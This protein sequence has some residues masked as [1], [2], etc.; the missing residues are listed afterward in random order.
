M[1]YPAKYRVAF[2]RKRF[3]ASRRVLLRIMGRMAMNWLVVHPGICR[4]WCG[5]FALLFC[6]TVAAAPTEYEVKAAFIHNV[7]K[8][9]DWPITPATSEGFL[10]FCVLGPDVFGHAIEV[11]K[12]KQIRNV[13]W[14][15]IAANGKTD[16]KECRVLFISGAEP[17]SLKR[18]LDSVKSSPVLTIGD[19]EGYAELGVIVNFYLEEGKVRFEINA[20]AAKRAG[21]KMSSQLLKLARI[22]P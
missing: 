8:F 13:T 7:A 16:L 21:L 12:D 6:A 15:V 19:T 22:V 14:Q 17:G 2:T 11:L 9:V 1:L 3:G 4:L 5:V 10:R 20:E 18:I